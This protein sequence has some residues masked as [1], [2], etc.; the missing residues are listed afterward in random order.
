MW[1][2][3][4]LSWLLLALA[5][6]CVAIWLPRWR[7]C[8]WFGC[9]AIGLLAVIAMTPLFANLLLGRLESIAPPS[10]DCAANP[11]ATAVVLGG[12]MTD[13]ARDFTDIAVLS[14]ASRRRLDEA[15]AWWRTQPARRLILSAGP[16]SEGAVP[17]SHLMR[18]Y[19]EARGVPRAA[20]RVEDASTTTWENAQLLARLAPAL[21]RR[22]VLITSASH[23]RRADYAMRRAGFDT[24]LVAVDRRH[25]PFALPGALIPQRSA[26]EKTELALHEVVGSVY[27][28]CLSWKAHDR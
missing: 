16:A 1:L 2:N 21:P 20:M 8:A 23:M 6:A 19:A 4:P 3:S 15:V 14:L 18:R 11:P 10:A 28:R 5:C 17:E 13:A 9:F 26:L 24:C 7:K 25:V 27:Y 12:G 22:V